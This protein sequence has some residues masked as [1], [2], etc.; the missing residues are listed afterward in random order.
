MTAALEYLSRMTDKFFESQMQRA[1]CRITT[2]S[3]RLKVVRR[4]TQR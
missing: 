1:A 3:T 2:A 4:N